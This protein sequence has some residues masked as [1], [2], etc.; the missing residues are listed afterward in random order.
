MTPQKMHQTLEW[1]IETKCVT[2]GPKKIQSTGGR[3]QNTCLSKQLR[4]LCLFS[5]CHCNS[6]TS[7]STASPETY[8]ASNKYYCFYFCGNLI[9]FYCITCRNF[10]TP[11]LLER[12][13]VNVLLFLVISFRSD[14]PVYSPNIHYIYGTKNYRQRL[15]F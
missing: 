14:N 8:N 4:A 12:K 1:F 13:Q 6:T 9:K 5:W 3:L 2:R 10:N 11:S 7:L 15:E